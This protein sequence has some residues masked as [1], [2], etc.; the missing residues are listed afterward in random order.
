MTKA[1][2]T[3]SPTA[4]GSMTSGAMT[5]VVIHRA[6][7]YEKLTFETTKVP[8]P[9]GKQVLIEVCAIGVN[10]ADV[11]VRMGMYQSA[12]EFVGWPIT[13]GFEV[14]GVITAVGPDARV[15]VGTP[16]Y[17]VTRFFGY[18]THVIVDDDY[19]FTKPDSLTFEQA[20]TIP[21]VFLTAWYSLFELAH[22]RPG[23]K[24]LVHSAAGGVGS[25]LLQLL[26]IL[27]CESV[28]VV[29]SSH[30]VA[31]AKAFGASHVIDKSTEDLWQQAERFAPEGYSV[32]L[33]ANGVS[34]LAQ[35]Y[36]HLRRS[37]KLVVYGFHSMLP[38]TGGR[39][40]W[41]RLIIDWLRTPRFNPIDMLPLSRSVMAF[42]LSYLFD[43]L[44]IV[45]EG[46][47]AVA[48]WLAEGKLVPPPVTTYP[49]ADVARAHRDIESGTTIGKLALIV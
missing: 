27:G 30:K 45:H 31:A 41:P 10:Y 24:V 22:P 33:D 16:V 13:P 44:D 2:T 32:I 26:K 15:A 21:A 19:V 7:S 6:G 38:K 49:F 29:G 28:G 39:A 43:R 20:A 34:T 25:T 14:S 3:S 4:A 8:A 36:G 23:H 12:K 5:R 40:N 11:L 42:N 17:A 46:M 37:G 9:T 35:S 48:G 1:P 47:G 18:S